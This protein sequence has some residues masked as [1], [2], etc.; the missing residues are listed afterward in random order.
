M[1][2]GVRG[3][4]ETD[5]F[6]LNCLV[7]PGRLLVGKVRFFQPRKKL[8]SLKQLFKSPQIVPFLQFFDIAKVNLS[9]RKN[10]FG[11]R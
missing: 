1:V 10:V 9:Y 7:V 11:F 3:N 4:G 2:S 6:T 8:T 5:P